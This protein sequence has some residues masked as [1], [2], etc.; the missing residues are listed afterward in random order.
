MR[1]NLCALCGIS[2][3]AYCQAETTEDAPDK[4]QLF[5]LQERPKYIPFVPPLAK[6]KMMQILE[7]PLYISPYESV[8]IFSNFL[9]TCKRRIFKTENIL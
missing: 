3:H 4:P 2:T 8:L 9:K 6:I 5:W 1:P 7:F